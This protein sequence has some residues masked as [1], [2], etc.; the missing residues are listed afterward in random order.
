MIVVHTAEKLTTPRTRRMLFAPY[1]KPISGCTPMARP[2]WTNTTSMLAFMATPM[3]ATAL[4][5]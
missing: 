1:A 2:S 5:P 4:S 3:P